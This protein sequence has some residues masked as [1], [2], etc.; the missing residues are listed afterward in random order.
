M[1][2]ILSINVSKNKGEIKR[3]VNE[4]LLIKDFGIEGDAHFGFG[5]RQVSLLSIFSLNRAREK[6]KD[7][8]FGDFAENFTVDMDLSTLKVGT[9]LKLGNSIISIS[10]IGKECHTRCEIYKKTGDCIM[11]KEGYFASVE[12]GGVVKVGDTIEI[13]EK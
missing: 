5:H 8:S 10:Q 9:K 7:L 3:P 4:V 11:P 2:K 12:E 1:G 13:V 6:N